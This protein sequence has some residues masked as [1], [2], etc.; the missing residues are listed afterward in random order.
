MMHPNGLTQLDLKTI[1]SAYLIGRFRQIRTPLDGKTGCKSIIK[2]EQ[3]NLPAHLP[4]FQ[5]IRRRC[6]YC[7]KGGI[8]L[9]TF[10]KCIECGILLCLIKE[11]ICFKKH[12]SKELKKIT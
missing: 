11:R 7:Y 2:F 10:L 9:K 6:E 3:G 8:D 12:H 1:V 5:N 4:E